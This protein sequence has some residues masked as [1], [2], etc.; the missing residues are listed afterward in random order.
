LIVLSLVGVSAPASAD[1]EG[2]TVTLATGPAAGF[3]NDGLRFGG[4]DGTDLVPGE[5]GSTWGVALRLHPGVRANKFLILEFQTG[6]VRTT[7]GTQIRSMVPINFGFRLTPNTG[8]VSPFFAA[9]AGAAI[10]RRGVVLSGR[11]NRIV[12]RQSRW[13]FSMDAGLGIASESGVGRRFFG[14][15]WQRVFTDG[16]PTNFVEFVSGIWLD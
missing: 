5:I 12:H 16:S 11:P 10:D 14:I 6:L 2:P 1:D 9:H 7:R 3:G 4:D 8:D 13:D 15:F